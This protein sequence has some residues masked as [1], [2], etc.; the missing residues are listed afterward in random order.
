MVVMNIIYPLNIT[1]VHSIKD[2]FLKY[3]SH[4]AYNF[5][6]WHSNS[7]VILLN[8]ATDFEPKID[9]SILADKIKYST[10]I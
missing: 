8:T 1:I 10:I 6:M 4:D 9:R 7:T 2:Y 3:F 5:H